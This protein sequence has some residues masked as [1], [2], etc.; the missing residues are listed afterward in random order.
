MLVSGLAIYIIYIPSQLSQHY[1]MESDD[2]PEAKLPV[3]EK[4]VIRPAAPISIKF[5]PR[6]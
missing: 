1:I 5:T 2:P 6:K 3:I 4:S